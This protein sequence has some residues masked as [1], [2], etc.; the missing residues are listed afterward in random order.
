ML[1]FVDQD[2]RRTPIAESLLHR[3]SEFEAATGCCVGNTLRHITSSEIRGSRDLPVY[4]WL[5]HGH[6]KPAE[7][8][9]SSRLMQEQV[10][11]LILPS[12][13]LKPSPVVPRSEF[14]GRL[15]V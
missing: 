15:I 12:P 11:D 1:S 6:Q 7:I 3:V 8:V 2:N 9:R 5:G 4:Q 14:P 13:C 10:V